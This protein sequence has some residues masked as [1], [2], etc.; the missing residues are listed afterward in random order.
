M[1]SARLFYCQSEQFFISLYKLDN[2]EI[3]QH[4]KGA[5][6]SNSIGELNRRGLRRY[7]QGSLKLTMRGFD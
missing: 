1:I 4:D 5:G 2:K 3:D 7:F 6:D